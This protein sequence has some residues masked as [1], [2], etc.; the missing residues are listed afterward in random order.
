[1]KGRGNLRTALEISSNSLLS[2]NDS[3]GR[4]LRKMW[5]KRYL[6]LVI[7]ILNPAI[8]MGVL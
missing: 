5:G 8:F 7:K 2:P 6:G 3:Q 4:A 1:M